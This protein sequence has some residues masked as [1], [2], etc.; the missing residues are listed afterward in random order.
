MGSVG[1]PDCRENAAL[2]GDFLLMSYRATLLA[3]LALPMFMTGA[4]LAQSTTTTPPG[5][6]YVAPGTT[7]TTGSR[8][9]GATGLTAPNPGSPGAMTPA[10]TTAPSASSSGPSDLSAS[11]KKFIQ[12]AA[13]GGMAEVQL[14]QLAQQKS[15]DDKVKAFAQKMIDDHTPNNEQLVKLA[16][17][18][19]VTPPSALDAMHKKEMA[20][21]EGLS[22][23]KFD[24]AY[25]KEQEK[26]HEVMLKLFQTEAKGGHDTDLKQFAET[27]IP[28]IQSHEQ[29]AEEDV[30]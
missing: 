12:K 7:G 3:A 4:A 22:G 29:M 18:K 1:R 24:K 27:T 28:T 25:L 14:A 30:K 20:K 26:D 9:P 23:A 17:D 15:S 11:D 13:I 19:G 6:G 21:L 16:T 8:G 5:T 2:T 10:E